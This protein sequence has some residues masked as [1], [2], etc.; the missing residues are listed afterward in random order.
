MV[1]KFYGKY[2]GGRGLGMKIINEIVV[3]GMVYNDFFRKVW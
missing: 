3:V 1:T 2:D